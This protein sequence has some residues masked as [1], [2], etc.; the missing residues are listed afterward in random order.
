MEGTIVWRKNQYML[1]YFKDGAEQL[2]PLKVGDTVE[3]LINDAWIR[4]RIERKLGE[5]RFADINY[6]NGIGCPGRTIE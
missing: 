3:V 1:Q 2:H 6:G 5:P 4:T